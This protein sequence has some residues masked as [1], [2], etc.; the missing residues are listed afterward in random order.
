VSDLMPSRAQLQAIATKRHDEFVSADPFPHVI[1]EDALP[2]ETIRAVIDAFP[3]PGPAW[4]HFDDP[5]QLK[6]ALRDE[7]AM[8]PPIRSVIQQFNSQV[9]VEFLET[10]TGIKGLIPDP[11]LL[12]G[13]LHQI[14]R[15]GT[16]KIHVDFD[17]HRQLKADR[18]L[19]VLLYLNEDW[20]DEYGGHF[21]LWDREMTHP[22]VRVAPEANRLVVFETSETSFHGHPDRLAVPEGRF[23]RSLAWYYYTTPTVDRVGRHNTLWADDQ[24]GGSR[25]RDKIRRLLPPKLVEATRSARAPKGT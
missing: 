15:G 23:R 22:V 6:F 13:G 25:G 9:F 24:G 5:H 11:H 2:A 18:R 7:E 8:P 19:N 1:I 14:P 20:L 16:L 12:G 4:Q 3:A 10:L 21:E 17:Q